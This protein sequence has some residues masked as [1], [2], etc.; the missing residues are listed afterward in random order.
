[1]YF[2]NESI[3]LDKFIWYIFQPSRM[4]KIVFAMNGGTMFEI[5]EQLVK[6]FPVVIYSTARPNEVIMQL[7][8]QFTFSDRCV[9]HNSRSG[10]RNWTDFHQLQKFGSVLFQIHNNMK[11]VVGS[12]YLASTDEE[13]LI[14]RTK[15]S[16]QSSKK[17]E[18]TKD[19]ADVN[20]WAQEIVQKKIG[21]E[22]DAKRRETMQKMMNQY[23]NLLPRDWD[24][25]TLDDITLVKIA[26]E[27]RKKNAKALDT[28]DE[29]D[30]DDAHKKKNKEKKGKNVS[31][32][33]LPKKRHRREQEEEDSI[34]LDDF[35]DE[36]EGIMLD[37]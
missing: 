23:V 7:P 14:A 9:P 5:D 20:R 35:L 30:E 21:E 29:E 6:Q 33:P 1:M 2:S 28:S 10:V 31:K 15:V 11:E 4:S 22:C 3:I 17:E 19:I 16:T 18:E 24:V 12:Y 37:N 26:K 32:K 13:T 36:D 34:D 8:T 27:R 25:G